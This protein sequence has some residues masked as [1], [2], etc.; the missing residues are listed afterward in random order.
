[1]PVTALAEE[2]CKIENSIAVVYEIRERSIPLAEYGEVAIRAASGS[3]RCEA[4]AD[5]VRYVCFV[6]GPGELF[7]EGGDGAAHAMVFLT[8]EM[9]EAHIYGDGD[10]TCGHKSEFDKYR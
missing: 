5:E 9:G 6:D 3:I 10:L 7:V 8:K 4:D 1:M 2:A